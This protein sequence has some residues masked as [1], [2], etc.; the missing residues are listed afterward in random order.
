MDPSLLSKGEQFKIEPNQGMNLRE[1]AVAEFIR[2]RKACF[3]LFFK[4]ISD[5]Q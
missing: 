3:T 2:S 1:S 5:Y 4:D